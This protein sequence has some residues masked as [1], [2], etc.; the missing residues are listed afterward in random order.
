M[1]TFTIQA[2]K[3][4]KAWFV[5]FCFGSW[6]INFEICLA[7]P[8]E[9]TVVFCLVRFVV[10]NIFRSLYS[11]SKCSMLLFPA[12]LVLRDFQIHIGSLYYSNVTTNVEVLINKHFSI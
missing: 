8:G 10:L 9:V 1:I 6:W 3:R 4:V 11:A 12:I 7:V 2:F 5:L